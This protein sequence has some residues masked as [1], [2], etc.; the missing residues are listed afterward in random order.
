MDKRKENIEF[1]DKLSCDFI[2][3]WQSAKVVVLFST[4][5]K[6][7]SENIGHIRIKFV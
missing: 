6:I 5:W 7:M 1:I 4:L 2:I 3:R